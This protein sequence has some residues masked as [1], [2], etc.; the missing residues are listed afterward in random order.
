MPKHQSVDRSVKPSQIKTKK[1]RRLATIGWREWVGLPDLGIDQIK[2]KIDTGARTSTLHAH[3]IIPFEQGG[4][5][6]VRFWV[7]PVQRHRVPN[8]ECIA[9][10][11]DRRTIRDSGGNIEA[12]YVVGTQLR[13]GNDTWP[14]ELTLTNRDEMS[15]RMLVGRVAVRGKFNI[16]PGTSF[17]ID[18]IANEELSTIYL[19]NSGD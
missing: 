14:V 1:K 19:P 6:F 16:D 11:V 5:K 12:R 15:F 8:I 9:P 18:R 10:I 13:M 17:R 7:H 2:A 3:H 4:I